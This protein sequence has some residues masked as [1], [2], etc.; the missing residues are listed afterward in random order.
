V[1]VTSITGTFFSCRTASNC[2]APRAI[3]A[4]AAAYPVPLDVLTQHEWQALRLGQVAL[5]R[6]RLGLLDHLDRVG[7]Q[8]RQ[9]FAVRPKQV[10]RHHAFYTLTNRLRSSP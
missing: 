9:R 5:P 3:S 10:A 7:T 2:D 6:E 1:T 8:P 4:S